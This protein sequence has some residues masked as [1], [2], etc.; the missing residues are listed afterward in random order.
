MFQY[1]LT[2]GKSQ[3]AGKLPR[4]PQLLSSKHSILDEKEVHF[5]NG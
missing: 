1:D 2:Q 4:C 3:S 5:Y